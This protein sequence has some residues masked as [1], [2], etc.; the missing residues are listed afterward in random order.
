MDTFYSPYLNFLRQNV[1]HLPAVEEKLCFETPA[2]YVADK[3]FARL[4][5]DGETLAINTEEREKWMETDPDTFF[6]TDHYLKSKYMLISLNTVK[7]VTLKE[8]LTQAWKNRA[9][10]KLLKQFEQ[11]DDDFSR[12]DNI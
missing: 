7:Q 6:I 8:L 12:N 2:F 4:K 11:Q 10:K 1:A 3:L 9:P 5:E